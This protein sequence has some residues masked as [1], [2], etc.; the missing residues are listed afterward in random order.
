MNYIVG[1]ASDGMSVTIKS[2]DRESPSETS[3]SQLAIFVGINQ[4]LGIGVYTYIS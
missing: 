2:F 1:N 4:V 3:F